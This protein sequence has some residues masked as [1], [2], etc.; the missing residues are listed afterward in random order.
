MCAQ[1]ERKR[2]LKAEG[3]IQAFWSSILMISIKLEMSVILSLTP[4]LCPSSQYTQTTEPLRQIPL[5]TAMVRGLWGSGGCSWLEGYTVCWIK[6]VL[7]AKPKEWWVMWHSTGD[8][9]LVVFHRAWNWRQSCLKSLWMI[10]RRRTRALLMNLQVTKVRCECWSAEGYEG[11]A[12]GPGQAG[13]MSQ[14]QWYE[15]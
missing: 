9:S 10:W 1:C 13:L 15:V 14:G 8:W 11:F 12:E 6:I 3:E 4:S 7:M 2:T 5:A